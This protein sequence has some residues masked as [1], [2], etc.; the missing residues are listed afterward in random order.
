MTSHSVSK[1]CVVF[2]YFGVLQ[3]EVCL[4]LPVV[5]VPTWCVDM[6]LGNVL[7]SPGFY[8]ERG[9]KFLIFF[10]TVAILAQGPALCSVGIVS[11]S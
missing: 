11:S 4:I 1:F 2:S 8:K 5:N 6:W 7:G 10:F 3:C 9:M